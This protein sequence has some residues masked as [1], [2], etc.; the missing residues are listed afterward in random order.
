M[1]KSVCKTPEYQRYRGMISR[2]YYSRPG[3]QSWR[4]YRGRGITVCDRWRFGDGLLTGFQCFIADMG[5][6]PAGH[7]LDRIDNDGPYAPHNCRWVTRSENLRNRRVKFN[8][9]DKGHPPS[10]GRTASGNCLVCKI[11]YD[12]RRYQERKTREHSV[13]SGA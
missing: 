5:M 10:V 8:V 4:N 1:S 2:C 6:P 12:K 9:C 11:A 7:D 13:P 3:S